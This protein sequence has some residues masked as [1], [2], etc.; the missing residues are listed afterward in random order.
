MVYQ[1][2][3]IQDIKFYILDEVWFQFLSCELIY[4]VLILPLLHLWLECI[5]HYPNVWR[6]SSVVVL[7]YLRTIFLDYFHQIM[8]A[9]LLLVRWWR[10]FLYIKD[11][12]SIYLYAW[13]LFY[14]IILTI[15]GRLL[16]TCNH[17]VT[18]INYHLNMFWEYR[19]LYL[20]T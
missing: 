6:I 7:E 15:K 13:L 8:V 9:L 1:D 11:W 12:I 16:M 18:I 2:F 17:L 3:E 14:N 19:P 20:I 4:L 10:I 5:I